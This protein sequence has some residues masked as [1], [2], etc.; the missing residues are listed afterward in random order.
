MEL[1][2]NERQETDGV[3]CIIMLFCGN[4]HMKKVLK[5]YIDLSPLRKN[6]QNR[7]SSGMNGQKPSSS[8]AITVPYIF[9]NGGNKVKEAIMTGFNLINCIFE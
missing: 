4:L 1:V 9:F 2:E 8:L 6:S 7:W 3:S 5:K